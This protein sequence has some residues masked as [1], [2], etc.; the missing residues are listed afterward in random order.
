MA[1]GSKTAKSLLSCG[2]LVVLAFGALFSHG[3]TALTSLEA[4]ISS[5]NRF[6]RKIFK[7]LHTASPERN[8]VFSPIGISSQ[9]ACF[10]EGA[11]WGEIRQEINRAFEWKEG[12]GLGV[13]HRML[14]ARF[15]GPSTRLTPEELRKQ[16]DRRYQEIVDSL[17]AEFGDVGKEIA[18][19][20]T[21]KWGMPLPGDPGYLPPVEPLEFGPEEIW[22]SNALLHYGAFGSNA[23]RERFKV[24]A[25]RDFGLEFKDISEANVRS[26]KI[27]IP[28]EDRDAITQLFDGLHFWLTSTVHLATKWRPNSFHHDNPHPGTFFPRSGQ[29]VQVTMMPSGLDFYFYTKTPAYESVILPAESVDFVVI[30]PRKGTDLLLLERTLAL[31]PDLPKAGFERRLGDVEL[32]QFDFAFESEYRPFLEKLGVKRIFE[33]LGNLVYVPRSKIMG[34]KQRAAIVVDREGIKAD[35]TTDSAGVLGGLYGEAEAFHMKVDRPFIFE[36]RDNVTGCLFFLGAIM[37]PSHH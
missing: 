20:W 30:L 27:W 33:D 1:I 12:Q 32:P 7:D 26:G 36:I 18:E 9:F 24:D 19:R 35:A 23:F 15:E 25:Q 4:Y 6:G 31:D 10:A 11:R 34:V 29:P 21:G 37:D 13:A 8:V 22:I 28:A 5:N 17:V 2:A 16:A 14:R 3:Q